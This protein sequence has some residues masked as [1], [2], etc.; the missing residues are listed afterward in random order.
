VLKRVCLRSS[1]PG[2]RS[3]GFFTLLGIVSLLE[4]PVEDH[5]KIRCE[6]RDSP[7]GSTSR[8]APIAT[9]YELRVLGSLAEAIS[10]LCAVTVLA[11]PNFE[12]SAR[13]ALLRTFLDELDKTALDL[14]PDW[15]GHSKSNGN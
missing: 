2:G 10:G 8:P 5:T 4:S 13:Q 12:D 1:R 15:N 14:C 3:I 11:M 9:D 7:S 6:I